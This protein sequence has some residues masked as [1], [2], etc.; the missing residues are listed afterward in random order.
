MKV[1]ACKCEGSFLYSKRESL[2]EWIFRFCNVAPA[3]A[4]ENSIFA[5][6]LTRGLSATARRALI[7]VGR[8]FWG[9]GSVGWWLEFVDHVMIFGPVGKSSHDIESS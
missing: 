1:A 9:L 2:D 7:S 3:T 6:I 5:L 4:A 8:C